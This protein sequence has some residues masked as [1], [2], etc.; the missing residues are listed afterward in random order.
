VKR[1]SGRDLRPELGG[2]LETRAS[3]VNANVGI[4][5]QQ[6]QWLTITVR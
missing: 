4:F 6:K 5:A 1:K 3:N 2:F